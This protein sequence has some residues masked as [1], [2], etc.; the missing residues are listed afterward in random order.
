M[1]HILAAILAYAILLF[2]LAGFLSAGDYW[3]I[4]FRLFLLTIF[5]S[6]VVGLI[7]YA[8]GFQP[9]DIGSAK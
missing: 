7:L 3:R 6:V 8:F 9:F 2:G 5:T 1:I 4:L